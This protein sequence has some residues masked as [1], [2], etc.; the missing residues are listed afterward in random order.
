[1]NSAVDL[2]HPQS[3][4]PVHFQERR[5]RSSFQT[6]ELER[7]S[8]KWS[9]APRFFLP[10]ASIV[11][12]FDS[13]RTS[14]WVSSH[15]KIQVTNRCCGIINVVE[16]GM[17]LRQFGIL[18]RVFLFVSFRRQM[19]HRVLEFFLWKCMYLHW[20]KSKWSVNEKWLILVRNF[21]PVMP[22]SSV[23]LH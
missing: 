19:G 23:E 4:E 18:L 22:L 11:P 13:D 8:K 14:E 3:S 16:F 7:C 5:D 1:M 2:P 21:P 20:R 6:D 12:V 15:Q 9:E 17:R 10:A